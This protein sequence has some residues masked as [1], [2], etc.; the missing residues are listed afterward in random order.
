MKALVAFLGILL[1]GCSGFHPVEYADTSSLR[2]SGSV[3]SCW[4]VA[5]EYGETHLYICP[6]QGE[7]ELK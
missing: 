7:G 6:E 5:D 2:S 1:A 4:S 3:G